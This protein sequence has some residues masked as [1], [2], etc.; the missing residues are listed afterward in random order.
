MILRILTTFLLCATLQAQAGEV[1]LS[2][3]N[4][5]RYDGVYVSERQTAGNVNYW[6]YLRFFPDNTVIVA[7]ST[8]SI[9]KAFK[10]LSKEHPGVSSGELAIRVG[11]LSFTTTVSGKDID[12]VGEFSGKHLYLQTYSHIT[13]TLGKHDYV[14]VPSAFVAAFKM[15]DAAPATGDSSTIG[16]GNASSVNIPDDF[17][18]RFQDEIPK[19]IGGTVPEQTF[20]VTCDADLGCVVAFGEGPADSFD[21]AMPTH[22][23]KYVQEALSYARSHRN[24]APSSPLYWSARNLRP[25]LDS[26]AEID[27]CID[28]SGAGT[29]EMPELTAGSPAYF[30]LCK[31]NGN[32]WDRPA[33]L[34]MAA[35]EGNCGDLFCSYEIYPAFRKSNAGAGR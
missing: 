4:L 5:V 31:L 14:F 6:S 1:P 27:S 19:R 24:V 35:R 28:L 2:S 9:E 8:D 10:W 15:P 20:A 29:K 22:S 23:L 3:E 13:K 25:L 7:A 11:K 34:F 30:L 12:Y 33:I 26:A 16:N 17:L 21:K 18:G 32:P